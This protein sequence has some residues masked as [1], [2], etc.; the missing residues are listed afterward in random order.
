MPITSASG[1]FA[2]WWTFNGQKQNSDGLP[3]SSN[4]SYN[5][6]GH[7]TGISKLS[8][9][10]VK[11]LL[12]W[13]TH[14]WVLL[15]HSCGCLVHIL[16]MHNIASS[17]IAGLILLAMAIAACRGLVQFLYGNI[18]ILCLYYTA[19]IF[20]FYH[21]DLSYL[22]RFCHWVIL[23]NAPFLMHLVAR[24]I[25]KHHFVAMCTCSVLYMPHTVAS[26]LWTKLATL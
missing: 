7:I 26:R 2:Y 16:S 20:T 21:A 6:E 4:R 11:N 13:H 18:I 19:N 14:G 9:W 23:F 22:Y 8:T 1:S 24:F 10:A 17:G 15:L 3:S 12:I 5:S 25:V